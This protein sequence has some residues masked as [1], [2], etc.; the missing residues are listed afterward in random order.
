MLRATVL[1]VDGALITSHRAKS[2]YIV[3][4]VLEKAF[5]SD[6]INIVLFG[7]PQIITYRQSIDLDAI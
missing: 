5:A 6:P 1:I 7:A 2:V 4:S 3:D